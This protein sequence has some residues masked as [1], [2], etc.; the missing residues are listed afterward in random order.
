M[1]ELAP[2]AS[3]LVTSPEYLMPPSDTRGTPVRMLTRAQS[4]MALSW[5]TPTPETTRVVQMEPG[6][7]PTLTPLAPASMSACVP[8]AVATLPPTISISG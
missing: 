4:A 2:A 1:T 5:G 6:P 3:A 8:W 7:T